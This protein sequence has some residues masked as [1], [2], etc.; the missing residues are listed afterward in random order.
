MYIYPVSISFNILA[1]F[2]SAAFKLTTAVVAV[3]F[4]MLYHFVSAVTPALFVNANWYCFPSVKV[5]P[6]KVN[7][8]LL[9]LPTIVLV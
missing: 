1:I 6:L 2:L 8:K 4:A 7:S 9:L 3:V 5:N